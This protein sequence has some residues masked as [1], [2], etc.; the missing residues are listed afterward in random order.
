MFEHL[1]TGLTAIVV[2]GFAARWIAWR[3]HL[4][5]ILLLLL[6]G[7]VAG[8][9]TGFLN[10]DEIFGELLLPIVSLSVAIILFEGGLSLS[11]RD[12][13]EIGGVVRNLVTIGVAVTWA[14]TTVAAYFLLGFDWI[15]SLLFGAV[16]VVTGPTVIIPLLRHV[17]PKGQIGNL[18]KW[19]GILNDPI[20]AL[21]AVVVYE[22]I[23]AGGFE[24]RGQ[25][26]LWHFGQSLLVG[27]L[28]GLAGAAFILILLRFHW[29]PDFLDNALSLTLVVGVYTASNALQ[30]E[31]GLL[32]TTVMG[33]ALAN[34]RFAPVK[35]IVEFKEH[36]RVLIISSLFIILSARLNVSDLERLGIGDFVFLAVLILIV[37]PVAVAASTLGSKLTKAE[38]NF[39]AWMAPRGIVAAAISSLFAERLIEFGY[40]QADRLV[41]VTFL[42]IIGTVTV[43]GLGAFPLARRLGLAEGNPQGVLLVGAH[44]WARAIARALKERGLRV[45]LV[46]SNRANISA[47]RLEG[48]TG[49][50]GGIH[51]ERILDQIDLYGISHLLALTSND[52]ANSLAAV[53]FADVF[54]RKNVYQL[55]PG[56]AEAGH[57][58]GVPPPHLSGKFAFGPAVTFNR[59]SKLFEQGATVKANQLTEKFDYAGYRERYGD[60]AI[61]L[62]LINEDGGLAVVAATSKIKPRA[63]Q[64][65]ISVVRGEQAPVEGNEEGERIPAASGR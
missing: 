53:H 59:L 6:C 64:T 30:A 18:V 13:R 63:G 48:L 28:V 20:G 29:V 11:F 31:S 43:Y 21:L 25:A 57:R 17:R 5:A 3:L 39:L 10:P 34:Q 2:L 58:P 61:P 35:H 8:P 42:V 46:D 1:L 16:L 45:V 40:E 27:T 44:S 7:I 41:P 12:L 4:P 56:D 51:S 54:G 14:L 22:A 32:A 65:L 33:M 37:R 15:V 52:E 9:V 50:Y 23:L 49:F 36:L 24:G 26:A 62:F 38:R 47:A 60:S 19:E 55:P